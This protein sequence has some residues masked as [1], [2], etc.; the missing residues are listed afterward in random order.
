MSSVSLP[1]G[2]DTLADATTVRVFVTLCSLLK[3]TGGM[4]NFK[5]SLVWS[6]V[7]AWLAAR[8]DDAFKVADGT[9]CRRQ[10]A[11]VPQVKL[12]VALKQ[13]QDCPDFAI[14][15]SKIVIVLDWC[16]S[17]LDA[18]LGSDTRRASKG[19]SVALAIR[20]DQV[21]RS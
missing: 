16:I 3:S 7:P 5:P 20:H 15:Q 17:N 4:K 1:E 12:P 2:W 8:G 19:A 13:L 21:S 6:L 14:V 9:Y 11:I 10:L 18:K